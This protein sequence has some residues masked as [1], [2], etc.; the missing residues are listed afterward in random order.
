MIELVIG[1]GTPHKGSKLEVNGP[2]I[3]LYAGEGKGRVVSFAYC[4]NPGESM[5]R[6]VTGGRQV[7]EVNR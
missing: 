1:N 2:V 3:T 4:M 7:Y 6:N 5:I